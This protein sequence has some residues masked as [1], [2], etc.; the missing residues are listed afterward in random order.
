VRASMRPCMHACMFVCVCVCMRACACVCVCVCV[1]MCGVW[2][3]VCVLARGCVGTYIKSR[4]GQNHIYI[5][6]VYTVF[7]AGN[8]HIYGHIRCIY[9]VLAN[10]N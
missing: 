8:H 4:V 5:Y 9:T 3:H 1:F 2:G 10:P 7:L 6:G